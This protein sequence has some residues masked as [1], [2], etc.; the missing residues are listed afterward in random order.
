MDKQ[1]LQ[2]AAN[3][4]EVKLIAKHTHAGVEYAPGSV[5]SVDQETAN[6][7]RGW[8]IAE[9][10]DPAVAITESAR[11]P[12]DPKQDAPQVVTGQLAES[13]E[14]PRQRLAPRGRRT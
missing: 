11:E 14:P 12:G 9:Q 8:K 1:N 2:P 3:L 6:I 10:H 13:A 7:L 4:V 5:L